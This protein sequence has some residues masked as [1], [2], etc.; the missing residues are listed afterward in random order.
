MDSGGAAAGGCTQTIPM[1]KIHQLVAQLQRAIGTDFLTAA[2]SQ[3]TSV[4]CLPSV[5]LELKQEA[6][7]N[8]RAP[9]DA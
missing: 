6:V 1:L 2:C 4:T 7:D 8:A 5:R 3:H 9:F